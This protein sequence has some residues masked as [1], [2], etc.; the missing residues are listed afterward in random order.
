MKPYTLRQ[1]GYAS[2]YIEQ[3]SG[4][5]QPSSIDIITCIRENKAY[6]CL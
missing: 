1:L 3:L 5:L 2:V 6:S 4:D